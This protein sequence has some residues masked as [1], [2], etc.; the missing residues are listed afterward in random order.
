MAFTKLDIINLAL[1]ALGQSQVS[2]ESQTGVSRR[3]SRFYDLE[4]ETE[5][6]SN[7][8]NFCKKIVA[9]SQSSDT[10]NDQTRWK[11]IYYI[12]SDCLAIVRFWPKNLDYDIY[13]GNLIYANA[14]TLTL[15][16]RYKPEAGYLPVWFVNY[17][18]LAI[19]DKAGASDAATQLDLKNIK[20]QKKNAY[21]TACFINFQNS[22]TKT[23]YAPFISVREY[24]ED[25]E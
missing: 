3:L 18:Y 8:W 16:Y 6:A 11:Y 22:P 13:G 20:M 12:P 17:F 15:E 19:A 23:F 24:N 25:E 10:P 9:L 4:L 14:S 2:T 5:C 21:S 1:D 7:Q